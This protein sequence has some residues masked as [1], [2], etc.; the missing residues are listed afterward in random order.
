[1]EC[2]S[3]DSGF[4]DV[5]DFLSRWQGLMFRIRMEFGMRHGSESIMF[6]MYLRRHSCVSGEFQVCRSVAI[7]YYVSVI[8][9]AA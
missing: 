2:S 6:A 8:W 4:L 1:M 3:F 7:S 9:V 5:R